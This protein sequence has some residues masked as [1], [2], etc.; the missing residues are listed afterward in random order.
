MPQMSTAY[1]LVNQTE[2]ALPRSSAAD[3]SRPGTVE[4]AAR[5]TRV[6]YSWMLACD[7]SMNELAPVSL[8]RCSTAASTVDFDTDPCSAHEISTGLRDICGDLNSVLT[9]SGR[10]IVGWSF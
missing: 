9:I 7:E 5:F 3:F 4:I 8:R 10:D 6:A 1:L 2:V